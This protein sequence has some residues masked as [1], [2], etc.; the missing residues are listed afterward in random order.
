MKKIVRTLCLVAMVALVATSCKKK[1]EEANVTVGFDET[2]GF[3]VGS[4]IE[5][6][7]KAY[8]DNGVFKWNEGDQIA[9][10]NLAKGNAWEQSECTV[11]TAIEGSEGKTQTQ[12][13][14]GEVKEMKDGYFVF[15]HPSKAAGAASH[16]TK[17][18]DNLETFTVFPTQT[19]EPALK[20]DRTAL[21]MACEAPDGGVFTLHHIFGF[22]NVAIA[23]NHPDNNP[24]TYPANPK[25]V[26][27]IVVR[28]NHWHLSGQ[29]DLKL[30][31][32]NTTKFN[33]LLNLL[34]SND[35]TYEGQLVGYLQ[36]LGYYAHGTLGNT[37]TLNCNNFELPWKAWQYFFIPLRPGA[38]YK[39]YTVRIN[40]G[41][42]TY[43]EYT[44]EPENQS[45]MK[46]LIKPGTF[47]N[48]YFT[49]KSGFKEYKY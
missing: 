42:N 3:Q 40:Y 14:G 9:F 33:R 43:F 1:E 19:Y 12:F 31:E 15:F 21:V 38:L 41:D 39:G 32:V 26:T 28:D 49:T 11:L 13:V 5:N 10:Y 36:D 4:D 7:A 34:E 23:S 37:I 20:M 25:T 44:F 35:E 18:E 48:A 45:D 2:T 24:S 22:L 30:D 16:G 6:D 8:I 47:R 29:L 17:G 27:S 46:Y